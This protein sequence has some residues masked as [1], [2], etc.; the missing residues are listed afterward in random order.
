MPNPAALPSCYGP[1]PG[2][3]QPQLSCLSLN[4]S[5][6]G[7]FFPFFFPSPPSQRMFQAMELFL[8]LRHRSNTKRLKVIFFLFLI[9]KLLFLWL[10][11]HLVEWEKYPSLH[12]L[13]FLL[14]HHGVWEGA[15]GCGRNEVQTEY[16]K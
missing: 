2:E 3:R 9:S 10:S 15:S 4:M 16:I 7:F 5:L 1:I 14:I 11:T 6:F 13:C 12:C 8:V